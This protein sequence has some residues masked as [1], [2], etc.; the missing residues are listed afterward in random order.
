MV[1]QVEGEEDGE[2]EGVMSG[3]KKRI[4]RKGMDA[5]TLRKKEF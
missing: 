1:D 2:K 5:D 4:K 3:K